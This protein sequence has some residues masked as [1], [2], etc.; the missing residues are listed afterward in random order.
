VKHSN[1]LVMSMKNS[2]RTNNFVRGYDPSSIHEYTFKSHEIPRLPANDPEVLNR[3]RASV[4][5]KVL[6]VNCLCFVFSDHLV[7]Y[8]YLPVICFMP[9]GFMLLN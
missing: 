8:H 6:V 9:L 2:N 3:M 4:S 7:R 1:L 5:S